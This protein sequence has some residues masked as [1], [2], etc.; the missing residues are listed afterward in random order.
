MISVS[1]NTMVS[2]CSFTISFRKF[3]Y[4]LVSSAKELHGAA[5]SLSLPRQV[6]QTLCTQI[7]SVTPSRWG[8]KPS[9][10][11][12][13]NRFIPCSQPLLWDPKRW[14]VQLN[15]FTVLKSRHT[16]PLQFI[17]TTLHAS[18]CW[19]EIWQFKLN[20]L[21]INWPSFIS[22]SFPAGY[23]AEAFKHY[24]HLDVEANQCWDHITT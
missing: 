24:S 20:L 17:Y 8:G 6:A 10:E 7:S 22:L 5:S 11:L 12:P 13:W 15:N 1:Q 9:I 2:F 16:V 18:D 21:K 19:D 14:V 4:A 3:F 23:A